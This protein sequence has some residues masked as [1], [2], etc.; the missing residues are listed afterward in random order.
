MGTR[1]FCAVGLSSLQEG[2]G[3]EI[4]VCVGSA[5]VSVEEFKDDLLGAEQ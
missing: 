2:V 4:I 3:Q 5:A 1:G